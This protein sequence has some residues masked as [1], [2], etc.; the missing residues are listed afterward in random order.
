MKVATVG[1]GFIVEWF[2]TSVE[3]NE[4]AKCVAVYSR[5]ETTGRK[6]ADQYHVE[7]VYTDFT[8]MLKDAEIDTVYVASPNSLHYHYALEALQAGKHVIC[9]K[10]FTST[11]D[12]LKH[13]IQVAK[14]KR[15]FLFEAIV[16]R[17]MPNYQIIREYVEQLGKI[18]MVQCNFS[19]YSSRYDKFL[20][21]ENPNVFNPAFSGGALM[22]L[23]IY[24]LHF[25]MGLFGKPQEVRYEP[26]LAANGIDTAGVL[27]LTYPDFQAV[28][29]ACKNCEAANYTQIQGENGYLLVNGATSLLQEVMLNLKQ[30]QTNIGTEEIMPGL[31]YEVKAFVSMMKQGDLDACYRELENSLAV[32]EVL[33]EARV[34]AGI[35]F[36]A[37]EETLS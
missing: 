15:L 21:G 29:I 28:C 19:Q 16:T 32:F 17:H 20:A 22:D 31:Y 36:A 6:L 24:N 27:L 8:E 26:S 9:E 1:T 23:N 37:D 10:P 14:A 30:K 18:R 33:Y 7:K 12:E 5:K 11:V 34:K 3:R 4:G 13:L 35:H 25:V 2:L